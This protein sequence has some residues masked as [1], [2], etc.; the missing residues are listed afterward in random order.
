MLEAEL[1][2]ILDRFREA[3]IAVIGDF[4]LDSYW[5][6]DEAGS[7]MSLETGL[8]TR[9][10]KE[11][12]YSLG[13]AGN[14]VMNL[15]ALGVGKVRAY[16]VVGADPFGHEMIRQLDAVG[17]DTSGMLTQS[18]EWSTHVYSK[19]YLGETEENRIDFGNFNVLDEATSTDLLGRLSGSLDEIDIVIINEQVQSGIHESDGFAASLESLIAGTDGEKFILDSR[20]H[21]DRYGGVVRKLNDL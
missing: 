1:K 6:L 3:S 8:S 2:Q 12:R 15:C 18:Q 20:H 16:G 13:G 21:S 19:P 10:V 4:C 14:V 9:A 7:E 11:Q 17:V 5:F